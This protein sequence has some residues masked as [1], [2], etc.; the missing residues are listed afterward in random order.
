M[1]D[2]LVAISILAR[3]G[4]GGEHKGQEAGGEVFHDFP[5]LCL[6]ALCLHA[7]EQY[8]PVLRMGLNGFL[9]DRH[10]FSRLTGCL[11]S[12]HILIMSP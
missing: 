5:F 2:V 7:V 8:F 3:L 6:Q 9:H 4:A 10:R 11:H 12:L 1:A